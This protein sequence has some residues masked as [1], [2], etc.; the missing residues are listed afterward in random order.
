MASKL[1]IPKKEEKSYPSSPK[2]KDDPKFPL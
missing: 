1:K 2:I